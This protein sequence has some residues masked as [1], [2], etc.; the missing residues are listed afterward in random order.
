[1]IQGVKG[2][3]KQKPTPPK[4]PKIFANLLTSPAGPDFLVLF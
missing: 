3:E 1:M 2:I 4:K